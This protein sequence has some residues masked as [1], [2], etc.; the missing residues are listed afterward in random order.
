MGIRNERAEELQRLDV[1]SL[2]AEFPSNYFV[3]QND[4]IHNRVAQGK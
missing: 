4:F 1:K 3:H 2:D